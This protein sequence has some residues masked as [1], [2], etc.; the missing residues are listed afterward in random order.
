MRIFK[1]LFVPIFLCLIVGFHFIF[2]EAYTFHY[3]GISMELKKHRLHH[4][5]SIYFYVDGTGFRL[6]KTYYSDDYKEV[7]AYVEKL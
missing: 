3:H 2:V 4:Y 7:H 5:C 6:L 1:I